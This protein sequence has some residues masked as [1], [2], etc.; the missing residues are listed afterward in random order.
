M[1]DTASSAHVRLQAGM[2]LHRAGD[3][4]GAARAYEAVLAADPDHPDALHLLGLIAYRQG[5]FPLALERVGEALARDPDNPVFLANLGNIRKDAGD[6]ALAI[7]SYRRALALDPRTVAPRN[8]LGTL[9]M[10]EGRLDEALACFREVLARAPDHARAWFN[11]GIASARQGDLGTAVDA[12]RRATGLQPEF[13]AAWGELGLALQR[14]G[15]VDDALAAL[16]QRSV[17]EPR[18]AAAHADLALALHRSGRLD[19]ARAAYERALA[20]EPD[21]LEV[22][23]N[24]CA[25]LQATC[26]WERLARCWPPVVEAIEQGRPGVPLGLLVA[27]PGVTPALQLAAAR[28]SATA[29]EATPAVSRAATSIVAGRTQRGNDPATPGRRL[30]VGY[31]SADFREHATAYLTAELFERH[32]RTRFEVLLLSYGPDDGSAMRARL[33]RAADRFIELSILSDRDAAA[34]VAAAGVD[35]LVDLNGNTDNGRMGIAAHRPAPIQVNWLGFPGTLGAS[36]YDCLIADATVIPPGSEHWYA[37]QV[38]R[39]PVCYQSN[40]RRR[41]RPAAASRAALGLPQDAVVLCCFNQ[42]FKITQMIFEAWLRVLAAVPDALLWLLE[43]NAVASAALRRRASTAGIAPARLVFAPRRPLAEHLARYRVADLAIDTFPC[44][45]HTTASDALWMGCPLITLTGDTFAS[46][47]ATSLV[48]AAGMPDAATP[49]LAAYE[50]RLIEL[51]ADPWSRR[52]LRERLARPEDQR[53]FDTA[54]FVPAFESALA[55]M[56]AGAPRVDGERTAGGTL[57]R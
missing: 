2:A 6:R 36:F 5:N 38:V 21:A 15:R 18:R 27:Q 34:A 10:D 44:T 28:A 26:D 13:A 43:D 24:L 31:L 53:L 39:L 16:R 41:P 33:Q 19:E 12:C 14:T 46:R 8:N 40:D 11:L 48:T 1:P 32:D 7:A 3:L 50:A 54:S 23:C 25:L 9:L 55:A 42:A 30:R 45:S 17:L 29:W 22:R 51:A 4:A 47:V 35:I 20:I 49:H 37:E 57:G 52:R 56:A